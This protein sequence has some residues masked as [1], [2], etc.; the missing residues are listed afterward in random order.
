M[1]PQ[2]SSQ[3]PDVTVTAAW[4]ARAAVGLESAISDEML[5]QL[6]PFTVKL[7]LRQ[8][9]L[10]D[11]CSVELVPD[12][13]RAASSLLCPKVC[14]LCISVSVSLPSQVSVFRS[15]ARIAVYISRNHVS[16]LQGLLDGGHSV[17][18][19][20]TNEVGSGIKRGALC[21]SCLMVH[22]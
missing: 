13:W 9:P 22:A 20:S 12:R 4:V 21:G 17:Y 16:Y 5:V 18:V 15:V 19:I 2:S 11:V 1:A 14:I 10:T 3:R 7:V 6:L 8:N